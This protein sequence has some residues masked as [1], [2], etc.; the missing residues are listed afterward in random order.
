MVN[1]MTIMLVLFQWSFDIETCVESL[2]TS[3]SS[4]QGAGGI[5][6]IC[7]MTVDVNDSD[8]STHSKEQ[9]AT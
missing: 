4:L 7:T 8:W 3:T 1:I 5:I 2:P 9:A 6:I